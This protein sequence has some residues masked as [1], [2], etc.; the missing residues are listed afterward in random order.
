M[1]QVSCSGTLFCV[2]SASL[3]RKGCIRV[4]VGYYSSKADR[5][6]AAQLDCDTLA[7]QYIEMVNWVY[8][9]RDSTATS[10]FSLGMA[11]FR[12]LHWEMVR[13][14]HEAEN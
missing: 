5:I 12:E 10:A 13:R 2:E 4:L 11:W 3:S 9:Q 1:W 6:A 8:E 7:Q 14:G